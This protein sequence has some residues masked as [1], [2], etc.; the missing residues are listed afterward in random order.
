MRVFVQDPGEVHTSLTPSL[1][2]QS[3]DESSYPCRLWITSAT[4][5]PLYVSLQTF[6]RLRHKFVCVKVRPFPRPRP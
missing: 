2:T 6:A 4:G 1:H 5:N 3:C